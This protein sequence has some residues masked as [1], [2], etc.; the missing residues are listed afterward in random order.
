MCAGH[1]QCEE[2]SDWRDKHI[3][4]VQGGRFCGAEH[5]VH[6]HEYKKRSK[7]HD[8]QQALFRPLLALVFALPVNAVPLRQFH[9][10]LYLPDSLLDTATAASAAPPIF[11]VHVPLLSLPATSLTAT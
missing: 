7:R 3:H 11:H 1:Q 6:D 2:T 5:G 4:H 9:L 8:D 10:P